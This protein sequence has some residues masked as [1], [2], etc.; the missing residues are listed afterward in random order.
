M[1]YGVTEKKHIVP[2]LLA[3]L[4]FSSFFVLFDQPH[5]SVIILL[6]FALTT[7]SMMAEQNGRLTLRITFF[8]VWMLTFGLF[9][10][11]S[12]IWAWDTENALTKGKTL[13]SMLVCYSLAYLCYQEFDS[14]NALIKSVLWGGNIVMLEIF[15]IYGIHGILRLLE[16]DDR[17]SEQFYLN[18]N[19]VGVLCA[20][21]M[22][23]NLYFILKDKRLYWWNLFLIPGVIL[24]SATGSRQALAVMVGGAVL[25]VFLFLIRG[26]SPAEIVLMFAVGVALLVAMLLVL[27]RVS[28]FSGIYKRILS[29]V[30]AVT[31]VGKTDRSATTRLAL[32]D[33]GI[34][35]LKQT[36]ILGIG[37]GSGHLVAWKYLNRGY[38][39]HNNYV[40]ILAGGGLTGF[41]IYY[42]IYMYIFT[43]FIRFR[44][45]A[46]QETLVCT[47]LLV[48]MLVVD[49]ANV[50]Y[51][52]KETYF[53]L[54][55]S[56]LE[57]EKLHKKYRESLPQT[58][59]LQN[60][61]ACGA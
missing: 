22:V 23:V 54:M 5:A 32:I 52:S 36:P 48:M 21:S 35:Q 49:Y 45:F 47:T 44:R 50:T 31:G 46:T 51:Y 1:A 16:Y 33:V 40:E 37:M 39:L 9:C 15:G 17:L 34:Y 60:M 38:Y 13:F 14:V 8:H 61:I 41:L 20:M 18:S 12:A 56:V 27:S 2:G 28:A 57:A 43:C 26:K 29:L 19:V 11:F 59:T 7:L 10:F 58:P 3:V 55:I 4:L 42:S 30:S 24:L 6:L 53:Y 25:L